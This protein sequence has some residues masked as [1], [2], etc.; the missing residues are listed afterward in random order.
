MPTDRVSIRLE[1]STIAALDEVSEEYSISRSRIIRDLITNQLEDDG[2]LPTAIEEAVPDETRKLALREEAEQRMLDR[3][4]LREKKH[5]FDDRIR[6]H[7]RDRLDTGTP[8]TPEGMADLAQGYKEDARIWFDSEAEISEK[9]R[10]VD[11]WLKTYKM[12]YW[13]HQHADE[14]ETEVNTEDVDGWWQVG[15]DI[16]KLSEHID[17]VVKRIVEVAEDG[18]SQLVTDAV[19]DAISSEWS[20]CEGAVLLICER[21]TAQNVKISEMIRLGGERIDIDAAN[22]LSASGDLSE[23]P[24][25]RHLSPDQSPVDMVD[26]AART[27]DDP[28]VDDVIDQIE[29]CDRVDPDMDVVGDVADRRID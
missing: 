10:K 5:S 25:S 15:E 4:K 3:Q 16:R 13:A 24:E 21:L 8:Y 1:R 18:S 7:F 6:G 12:G 2:D 23:L 22:A 28:T 19:V 14:V 27:I 20:V 9:E 29:R 11:N 26:M 17:D